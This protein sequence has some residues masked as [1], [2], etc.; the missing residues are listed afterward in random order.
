MPTP[1][2]LFPSDA[3]PPHRHQYPEKIIPKF[4]CLLS[5]HEKLIIHGDG[6]PTRRYL[7]GADAADAFDFVL[8]KGQV[9]Q[10]YNVASDA[11]I[12][13]LDLARLLL[14]SSGIPVGPLPADLARHVDFVHDRPFNDLRYAVDGTKLKELGWEQHTAFD[15][16]LAQTVAWYRT[17]G[18]SWWGDLAPVLTAFPEELKGDD[19]RPHLRAAS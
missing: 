16:G 14:S 17:W 15:V 4:C 6:T 18:E 5:R 19:G 13:N 11:E 10:I 3:T 2:S 8:S 1:P 9:G 12:S 7:Y